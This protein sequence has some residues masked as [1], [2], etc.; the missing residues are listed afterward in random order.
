MDIFVFSVLFF[1][2]TLPVLKL[3]AKKTWHRCVF[4]LEFYYLIVIF[5]KKYFFALG[6]KKYS[7]SADSYFSYYRD[8]ILTV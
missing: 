7:L 3:T 1:L 8:G 2:I 6:T 4:L 5:L